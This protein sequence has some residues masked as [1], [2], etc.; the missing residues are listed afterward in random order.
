MV[1]STCYLV[2]YVGDIVNCLCPSTNN[3][4]LSPPWD[5]EAL[6]PSDFDTDWIDELGQD[7]DEESG[8]DDSVNI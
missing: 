1:E 7:D 5:G 4:A 3:R 8:G 2:N 6:P